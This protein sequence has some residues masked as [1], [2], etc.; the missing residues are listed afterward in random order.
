MLLLYLRHDDDD[1]DGDDV[2]LQSRC[3]DWRKVVGVGCDEYR[4]R[5]TTNPLLEGAENAAIEVIM[6]IKERGCCICWVVILPLFAGD[7]SRR[8]NSV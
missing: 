6:I 4:G 7:S 5:T 1:D 3:W 8:S 2:G